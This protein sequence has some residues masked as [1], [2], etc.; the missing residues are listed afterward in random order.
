MAGLLF[1]GSRSLAIKAT[2]QLD[3][4]LRWLDADPDSDLPRQ[5]VT[6]W[7]A[8]LRQAR[9]LPPQPRLRL[10]RFWPLLAMFNGFLAITGLNVWPGRGVPLLGF[11]ALFWLVPVLLWLWQAMSLLTA[12][13]PWWR[14]LLTPHQDGVIRRWCARQAVLAQLAFV[15]AAL[16]GL[17]LM[18]LGREVVFYWS[19]SI[20]AIGQWIDSG[21]AVL[22]LGLLDAPDPLIISASQAG[23]ISGWQQSL[24]SYS[25][26]WALWLTQVVMLWVV[27]PL[28]LLWLV[29]HGLLRRALRHWP[30][31][32]R[33]LR[34]RFQAQTQQRVHY[35]PLDAADPAPALVSE[36]LPELSG[37]PTEP[38]F[39]WQ[40]PA[41]L[42]LPSGSQRLGQV[43]QQQDEATIAAQA[44]RLSAWYCPARL[45]PTGDL[46]DLLQHHR[47]NGGSPQLY[48]LADS[49]QPIERSLLAQNW[50]TFVARQQLTDLS[51]RLIWTEWPDD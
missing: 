20:P 11:L 14:A 17:W 2:D 43:S 19:T 31:H 49:A 9:H 6:D 24:L 16:V 10:A 13:G 12:A 25:Y 42:R 46:A 3:L 8:F 4:G 39:G 18:L 22:T 28:V 1:A 50:R 27:L 44:S 48:L 21:L 37:A 26:Y 41:G 51:L 33:H 5:A 45:V 32:N 38:G 23:A 47:D 15:L 36:P 34:A 29:Q 35:Q 7:L 40:L 30:E